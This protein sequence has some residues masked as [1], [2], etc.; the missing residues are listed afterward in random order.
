MNEFNNYDNEPNFNF[1]R[2]RFIL[3]CA[4]IL[5]FI[6]TIAVFQ[7]SKNKNYNTTKNELLNSW[8]SEEEQDAYKLKVINLLQ[9]VNWTIPALEKSL[10]TERL[11]RRCLEKQLELIKTNQEYKIDYCEDTWVLELFKDWNEVNIYKDENW[12]WKSEVKQAMVEVEQPK[13][14]VF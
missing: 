1:K 14:V 3:I 2:I 5:F 4:M 11:T 8:I 6:F 13:Q 10:R 12:T 7:L 9:E